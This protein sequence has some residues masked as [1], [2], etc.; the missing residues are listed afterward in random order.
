MDVNP[1]PHSPQRRP[2][3]RAAPPPAPAAAAHRPGPCRARPC[4]QS[5]RCWCAAAG[6]RRTR[7]RA[8]R[9]VS[10]EVPMC[11]IDAYMQLGPHPQCDEVSRTETHAY[12]PPAAVSH[13]TRYPSRAHCCRAAHP[14]HRPPTHPPTHIHPH[15]PT[16]TH[17]PTRPPTHPHIH[18][19]PPTH[20]HTHPPTLAEVAP[21]ECGPSVIST[22]AASAPLPA[23]PELLKRPPSATSRPSRLLRTA[24]SAA[25]G[26][27][28]PAAP[29]SGGGVMVPLLELRRVTPALPAS[30][31]PPG[32]AAP[33]LSSSNRCLRVRAGARR[34][35]AGGGNYIIHEYLRKSGGVLVG[36]RIVP[37]R[38][39]VSWTH[40]AHPGGP[41]H[42]PSLS[43]A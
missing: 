4:S 7:Q 6:R 32:V 41:C 39:H 25:S 43:R 19:H 15:P 5:G 14:A 17:P 37:S 35:A 31:A 38:Q 1:A 22:A 42:A 26:S 16:P 36:G 29:S 23:R 9:G 2:G 27:E 13:T 3:R 40:G 28:Q 10:D 12:T 20:P 18:T 11:A 21:S 33:L 24:A 34:R 30:S 8:R